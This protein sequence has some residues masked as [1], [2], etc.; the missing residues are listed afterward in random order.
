MLKVDHKRW[1]DLVETDH[2][3]LD[4]VESHQLINEL[5]DAV[6]EVLKEYEHLHS[7]VSNLEN[8]NSLLKASINNQEVRK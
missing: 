7:Y 5:K 4:Q 8:E 3:D 6:S 1:N 2:H